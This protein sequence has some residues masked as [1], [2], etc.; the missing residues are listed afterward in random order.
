MRRTSGLSAIVLVAGMAFCAGAQAEPITLKFAYFSSDRTSTYRTMVEP[1]VDAVNREG[2]GKVRIEVAFSGEL[3]SNPAQQA[4]L[5]LD[6]TADLAFVIPGYRPDMFPDDAIITMP[7]MYES[8]REATLTYNALLAAGALRGRDEF[9]TVGAFATEPE[10]IHTREPVDS[11]EA[12]KGLRIRVNNPMEATVLSKLDATPVDLPINETAAALGSGEID[13]ATLPVGDALI[14]FGVARMTTNHYMLKTSPVP[15]TVVMNRSVFE[16]LPADIRDI[17][18][19]YSGEWSA[20]RYIDVATPSDARVLEE[21]K[22]DPKRSVV[23]PTAADEAR[24]RAIFEAVA[25]EWIAK[26]PRNRELFETAKAKLEK[27]R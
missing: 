16:G 20:Q 8:A 10:T 13:G 23:E 22:S 14:E 27:F 7:G 19:K 25:E 17:I 6:G 12:L 4:Q 11:L 15:L 3:G 9:F 18:V 24:A 5:V 26:D 1:F 2:E 21:F